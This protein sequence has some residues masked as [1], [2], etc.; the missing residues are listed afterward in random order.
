MHDAHDAPGR[1]TC[2]V[3]ASVR[4]YKLLASSTILGLSSTNSEGEEVGVVVAVAVAE[5]W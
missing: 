5:L 2:E 1:P 4:D 3:K